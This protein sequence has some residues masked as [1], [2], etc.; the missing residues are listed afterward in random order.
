[1]AVVVIDKIMPK[2]DAFVGLVDAGQVIGLSGFVA[3]GSAACD[4]TAY[5]GFVDAT[6]A[7]KIELAN[8]SGS[9]ITTSEMSLFNA[10][11][12]LQTDYIAR[13]L[14]LSGTLV[15]GYN[16]SDAALSGTLHTELVNASGLFL[17]TNG[18]LQSS[19]TF[20]VILTGAHSGVIESDGGT[21][22]MIRGLGDEPDNPRV[23]LRAFF[24]PLAGDIIGQY[25]YSAIRSSDGLYQDWVSLVGWVANQDGNGNGQ[26]SLRIAK[27]GVLDARMAWTSGDTT[28]WANFLMVDSKIIYDADYGIYNDAGARKDYIWDNSAASGIAFLNQAVL[29]TSTPK[30]ARLGVGTPA[31]GTFLH[32]VA[33]TGLFPGTIIEFANYESLGIGAANLR[34]VKSHTD[35]LNIAEPTV[36]NEPFGV[37]SA[38]GYNTASGIAGGADI[39]FVQDGAGGVTYIPGRVGFYTGTSSASSLERMRISGSGQISMYSL[40]YTNPGVS[41]QLWVN[42]TTVMMSVG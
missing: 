8:A 6:Y 2:N 26:A 13:D 37:I 17:Q 28:S 19:G 11:G 16:T 29:T 10:S 23:N 18:N 21:E 35:T 12:I 42:G 20:D 3:S 38:L 36:A 14:A 1:M 22:L 30:F 27:N 5:S 31:H 40:P 33:N 7:S 34:F 15:T 39:Y 9:I 24:T 32:R 41:G 25:K 4:L